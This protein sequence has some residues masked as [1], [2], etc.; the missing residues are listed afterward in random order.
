MGSNKYSKLVRSH[1]KDS[2]KLIQK[3]GKTKK[4]KEGTLILK[5]KG[6]E[7]SSAILSQK[8]GGIF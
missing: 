2:D 3:V 7:I 4:A 8:K 6:G 5:T 1:S